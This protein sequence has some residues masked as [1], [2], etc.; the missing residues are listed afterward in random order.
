MNAQKNYR[1]FIVVAVIAMLCFWQIAYHIPRTNFGILILLIAV[2]FIG[3]GI[4]MARD[5]AQVYFQCGDNYEVT[6]RQICSRKS[7]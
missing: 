6:T 1:V 4:M 2:L 3:Y 5:F 7:C